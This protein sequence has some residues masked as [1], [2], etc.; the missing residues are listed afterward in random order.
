M[1]NEFIRRMWDVRKDNWTDKMF[2]EVLGLE[3][4]KQ[5][6]HEQQESTWNGVI[7]DFNFL[8]SKDT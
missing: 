4:R 3:G 7:S 5:R 8:A 2:Q 6:L 1:K